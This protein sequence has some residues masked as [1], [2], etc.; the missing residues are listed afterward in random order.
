[1][2]SFIMGGSSVYTILPAENL[3]QM[4]NLGKKW[5]YQD[6]IFAYFKMLLYSGMFI[7]LVNNKSLNCI[8]K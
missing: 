1:M 2:Q 7:I 6:I 8:L 5:V 4:V 3:A